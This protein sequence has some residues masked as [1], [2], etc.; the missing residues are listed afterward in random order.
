MDSDFWSL[1]LLQRGLS[2]G[3]QVGRTV[4]HG[5]VA[6]A[7]YRKLPEREC[8]HPTLGDQPKTRGPLADGYDYDLLKLLALL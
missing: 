3:P 1:L 6:Q 4:A 2:T 8:K 5:E 7:Q